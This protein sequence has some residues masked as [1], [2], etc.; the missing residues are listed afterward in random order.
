MQ[1]AGALF[2]L[3]LEVDWKVYRRKGLPPLEVLRGFRL[4]LNREETLCLIG[5]SGIGKTTI[6]RILMGLDPDFEGRVHPAS[7]GLSVGPVFQEPRLLPWRT[8]EENVRL[9]LPRRERHRP[10][11]DLLADLRLTEWRRRYPGELSGGLARRV[12]L[13]RALVIEPALLVLDEPFISLDERAAADLRAS[14]F[15]LVSRKRM[16][17]LMVTHNVREAL[18]LADRLVLLASRPAEVIAEIEI[19]T[20][21]HLRTDR[22]VEERLTKLAADHPQTISMG[23][24]ALPNDGPGQ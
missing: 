14:V 24:A 15:D 9:A 23:Q 17:V 3:R 6:L 4:V 19:P 5:P 12:A 1:D 11:D 13:A 18:V 7:R 21:R 16:S 2:P 10:I 20:P 8:V 22:W